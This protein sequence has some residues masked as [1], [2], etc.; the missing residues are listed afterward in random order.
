MNYQQ[1]HTYWQ[2]YGSPSPNSYRKNQQSQRPVSMVHIL[3]QQQ[4]YYYNNYSPPQAQQPVYQ[5]YYG[6][7]V[8]AQQSQYVP[9]PRNDHHRRRSMEEISR[10]KKSSA[11]HRISSMDN[12]PSHRT[13]NTVSSPPS[14]HH[15]QSVDAFPRALSRHSIASLPSPRSPPGYSRTSNALPRSP[16][17]M[18]DQQRPVSA[19]M[20]RG[21]L[22]SDSLRS[23]TNDG[24]ARRAVRM[25]SIAED[26]ERRSSLEDEVPLAMLTNRRHKSAPPVRKYQSFQMNSRCNSTSTNNSS[27]PSFTSKSS[28][29]GESSVTSNCSSIHHNSKYLSPPPTPSSASTLPPQRRRSMA[30][31][32]FSSMHRLSKAVISP[33]NSK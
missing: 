15:G 19:G 13:V 1:Q 17:S 10:R 16:T 22:S 20:P 27:R 7:P 2:S 29:S 5:Y 24:L 31:R 6:I 25:A 9:L 11:P 4:Q 26:E 14:L 28:S 33:A 23:R 32:L 8:V 18:T 30:K 12:L 3:P 21:R